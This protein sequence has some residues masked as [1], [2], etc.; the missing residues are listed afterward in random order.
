MHRTIGL[1]N[2]DAADDVEFLSL[3][4][5]PALTEP[6]PLTLEDYDAKANSGV[7]N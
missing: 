2:M 7:L 5:A 4:P 3:T 6:L 1:V